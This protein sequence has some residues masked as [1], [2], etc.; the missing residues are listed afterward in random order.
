MLLGK[1]HYRHLEKIK[2]N[3]LRLNRGDLKA[4]R[5]N[6]DDLSHKE[7]NWWKKEIPNTCRDIHVPHVDLQISNDAIKIDW[8]AYDGKT[9]T[10]VALDKDRKDHVIF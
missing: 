6:L 1:L 3:A 9:P 5:S 4:K 7:L 2:S 10:G 8:G